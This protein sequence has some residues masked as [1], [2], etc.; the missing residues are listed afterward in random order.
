MST[1]TISQAPVTK[2]LFLYPNGGTNIYQHTM[3]SC[4]SNYECVDDEWG[5][6]DD[7]ETYVY[8]TAISRGTDMYTLGNHTSET[9]TINSVLIYSRAKSHIYQQHST[10]TYAILARLGTTTVKSTRCNITTD[11]NL[12]YYV[13][14]STPSGAAWDWNAVDNLMIGFHSS[15]P[16]VTGYPSKFYFY[17]NAAG[18]TT[19]F[20]YVVGASYHWDAVNDI[21]PDE[22]ITEIQTGCPAYPGYS[23]YKTDLFHC[24]NHTTQA[25]TINSIDII[26]RIN[27]CYAKHHVCIKMPSVAT[28]YK[29]SGYASGTHCHYK[30]W[31]YNW[32]STP[33]GVTW[34]WADIDALQIGIRSQLWFFSDAC[35][36][37]S[38]TQLYGIVNYLADVN[39]EIRT[40]QLYA[41]VN[42]TP[43]SSTTVLNKPSSYTFNHGRNIFTHNW[44]NGTRTVRDNKRGNKTLDMTGIEYDTTTSTASTRLHNVKLLMDNKQYVTF[45]GLND[46]NLNTTWMIASFNYDRDKNNTNI[47]NWVMTCEA[48]T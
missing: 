1:F 23:F 37:M 42:Y 2:N 35:G 32:A 12:F 7:D 40:T 27:G 20:A 15:S 5:Y 9:G 28:D 13:L 11:Y 10:G 14:N 29:P 45:S 25:G 6:N 17:P 8:R 46:V 19:E 44:W 39:P 16:T 43:G 24:T 47:Y 30:D 18:D 34:K 48:T 22:G 41:V 3:S 33:T 4:V 36:S 26:A 38:C 21:E 31:V